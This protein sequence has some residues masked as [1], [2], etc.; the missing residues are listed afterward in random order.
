MKRA[1]EGVCVSI[2]VCHA[3]SS[4]VLT[5]RMTGGLPAVRNERE[6]S[7]RICAEKRQENQWF[8]EWGGGGSAAAAAHSDD[9]F[10]L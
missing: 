9:M 6:S 8:D 3:S 5:S 7:I 2:S 1:A 4:A 10:P